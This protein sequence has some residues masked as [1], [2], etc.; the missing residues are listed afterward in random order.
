MIG[1]FCTIFD[2]DLMEDLDYST[3]SHLGLF[4]RGISANSSPR[5]RKKVQTKNKKERR[6]RKKKE[7]RK[8]GKKVWFQAR[9]SVSSRF[10]D[11]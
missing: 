10:S 9:N 4:L 2:H 7:G 6:E 8:K 5:E 1:P 11:F 3:R